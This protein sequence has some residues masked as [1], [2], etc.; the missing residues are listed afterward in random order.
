MGKNGSGLTPYWRSLAGEFRWPLGGGLLLILIIISASAWLRTPDVRPYASLRATRFDLLPLGREELG[1]LPVSVRGVLLNSDP[2]KISVSDLATAARRAEFEPRLPLSDGLGHALPSPKLSVVAPIRKKVTIRA[3]ELRD[4]L[5]RIQGTDLLVPPTWH[6]VILETNISAGI[7]ADYGR[8][9][10][11]QRLPLEFRAPDDFPVDRFLEVL[12]RIG[13][14]DAADAAGLGKR[15]HA[16]PAEFLL[17]APRYRIN[18]RE[19][20]VAS[21]AGVLLR[22]LSDDGL[23]RL[24]LAWN[25]RDRAYFLSGMGG[26]TEVEAMAIANSLK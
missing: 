20:Q 12:F 13:G 18:P 22:Y 23:E 16:H 15:F 25:A 17:V 10:L 21:G 14:L 26:L 8:F 19:V 3:G 5:T 24:T 9:R 1:G 7:V 2:P 6:G 11:G 4:A